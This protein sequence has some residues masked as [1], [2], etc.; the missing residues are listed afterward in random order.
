MAGIQRR[1]KLL[2]PDFFLRVQLVLLGAETLQALHGRV[3][4]G[5]RH[6]FLDIVRKLLALMLLLGRFYRVHGVHIVV[7]GRIGG[8]LGQSGRVELQGIA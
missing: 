7:D 1:W 4:E 6:V 8:Q 5:V 3:P 2:L